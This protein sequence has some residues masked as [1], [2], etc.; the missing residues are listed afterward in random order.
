MNT[1]IIVF[2]RL[3][4][5]TM[6]LILFG[7]S[8]DLDIIKKNETDSE[9][10]LTVHKN[11][12]FV[13]LNKT[14]S[15]IIT[16]SAKAKSSNTN[17]KIIQTKDFKI[18]TNRVTFTTL[19]DKSRESYSFYI[20]R[21]NPVKS[22]FIENLIFAKDANNENYR[23]Y[24]AT[25]FFPDGVNS[26]H[27]N[28]KVISFKEINSQ[29]L[30]VKNLFAKT[31]C[32]DSY[33]Y[34]IIETGHDCHSGEHNGAG[35]AGSC[36]GGAKPYSTYSIAVLI[37]T[38]GGDG[39]GLSSPDP[40]TEGGTTGP[41]SPNTGNT[42]PVDT[43]MTFPSPCQTDDCSEVLVVN[44][45][46]D[47]LNKSLDYNQLEWLSM[48]TSAAN[49]IKSFLVQNNTTEAKTFAVE[50]I[51]YWIANTLNSDS[52]TTELFFKALRATN[53]F[54]DNLT[55]SFV[56]DNIS[57]FSQDVQNQILIDPLLAA[58]I[59]QEYLIQRAV[60]KYLHPNW[61]EVQ[62]YYSVLWDLRHMA[63][64]AFG[65]I[66]VF[67]EVADLV[68]GTLYT[69]EGDEVNAAFSFAS[70]VPV[71]GWAT[72]TTKYAIKIID[73]SQTATT[74]ATKVKLTWKV[75]GNTIEFGNRNQLRKVLGITASNLQAHH[76]I[77]WSSQTKMAV[78]RAAKSGNAFH[79]NE[80]LNG[81]EVAAW[82]NQPNHQ[83]YND[84]INAKLDKFRDDFPNATPAQC[85]TFL[86]ELI[87]DIK[88]WIKNNP[89]SH[90]NDIILP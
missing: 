10:L 88:T 20:E 15:K 36:S 59:A 39:G 61:N 87:K 54:Q 9:K 29:T 33:T 35:Q 86:T 4:V 41:T 5:L 19:T 66:P 23:A 24:I 7:C 84:I 12:E 22:D 89:N 2:T 44:E 72:V 38:C 25:Y 32:Q 17:S 58:Q 37:S 43:G 67:G 46:N 11:F 80:A 51:N 78:Q 60:K 90:L 6:F 45:I 26:N 74:I 70:A 63:L 71:A 53:N 14:I 76:L 8:S 1:K 49:E 28:F 48:N 3:L 27:N 56:Q 50:I 16:N 79:M 47:L 40:T 55:E 34:T 21:N 77:P 75:I 42:L 62:I 30:S 68:N 82:R 18:F 85:Y 57:Y 13:K 69:L 83:A 73:A 52:E 81:I 31:A 65:L 64:D